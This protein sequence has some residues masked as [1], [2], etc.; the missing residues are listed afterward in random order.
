MKN[1]P[2]WKLHE[3]P[4]TRLFQFPPYEASSNCKAINTRDHT[5]HFPLRP[6]ETLAANHW[7]MSP[8]SSTTSAS[9]SSSGSNS[10][11]SSWLVH[12]LLSGAAIVAAAGAYVA[13]S[14]RRSAKFRSR[15]VGIIPA[16]FG[17]S[18]FQGKPLVPILGKPMIQV[19][20]FHLNSEFRIANVFLWWV[21]WIFSQILLLGVW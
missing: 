9:S 2:Y 10:T 5:R 19:L 20:H 4:I 1:V 21:K 3:R 8:T 7:T 6:Q 11:T 16:R 13:I 14:T 12:G 17:S 18:R 15:V